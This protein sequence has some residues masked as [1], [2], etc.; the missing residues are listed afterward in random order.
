MQVA[1]VVALKV[2]VLPLLP[3]EAARINKLLIVILNHKVL[4]SALTNQLIPLLV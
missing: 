2:Q 3:E 4:E 1:I